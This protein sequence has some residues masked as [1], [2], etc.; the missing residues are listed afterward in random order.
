MAGPEAP[1]ER[2]VRPVWAGSLGRWAVPANCL[3]RRPV[4]GGSPEPPA[5]AVCLEPL[6][7]VASRELPAR[8]ASQE[9]PA[10]GVCLEPLA[11]V[12]SR[13]L[14]ARVA[15]QEPPALLP[16]GAPAVRED[17][18]VRWPTWTEA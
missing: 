15:S 5:R 6:A 14:P 3:G 1:A 18:P 16:A 12:A 10:R 9:P 7:R 2:P 4:R 17:R 8:V 11:R 13:E